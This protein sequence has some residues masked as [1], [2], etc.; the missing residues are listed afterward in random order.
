[1]EELDKLRKELDR[2]DEQM[3]TLFEKRMAI[4]RDVARVKKAN[5][6]SVL[7]ASREE[8][9]LQSRKEMLCDASLTTSLEGF[10][11]HLMLLSRQEQQYMLKEK[12]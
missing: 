4:I 5:N 2:V 7:D 11:K 9:V 1:M 12:D 6:L 3:V 10:Y 8:V